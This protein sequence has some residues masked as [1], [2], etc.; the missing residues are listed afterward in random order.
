MDS[1]V[2]PDPEWNVKKLIGHLGAHHRWVAASIHAQDPSTETPDIGEPELVDEE[3]LVW[4]EAGVD[5]LAGLLE[6]VPE[7]RPAWSWAGDHRKGFWSR[8]TTVETTIHRWDVEH[9]V[10]DPTP[11]DAELAADGV[12]E[13][14]TVIAPGESEYTGATGTI[15]LEATDTFDAWVLERGEEEVAFTRGPAEASPDLRVAGSAEALLLCL[16]GRGT[17]GLEIV[18]SSPASEDLFAWLT[19]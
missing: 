2:F 19:A 17:N 5:E 12:D 13:M 10:G 16:W 4:L 18:R 8:R 3:L 14:A 1:I 11:L 15:V 6:S 9:A 7:E